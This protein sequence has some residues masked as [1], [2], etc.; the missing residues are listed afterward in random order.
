MHRHASVLLTLFILH[1]CAQQPKQNLLPAT[2]P[3]VVVSPVV[4]KKAEPPA[5][6]V[7]FVSENI[8]AYAEVAK[9]LAK[10]LGKKA[11]IHYLTDSAFDNLRTVSQFKDEP[12]TQFVS[13]GLNAAIASNT[14]SNKQLV[15]CQVYNYQ[16]YA[17]ISSKHKG[18]SMLPSL[19]KTFSIW[20]ALSPTTK[21]IGIITG[22]GFEDVMQAANSAAKK[23]GFTLHF[24]VV[25]TDK[26]YQY[27]YKKM[28]NQVQGYWLLPDNRV[29]SENILRDIMN[30]S[31]RNS[32]QVAVFNDEL[33]KLGGLLSLGSETKDIAQ[34]V[35]ERLEQ[36]QASEQMPGPDIMYP[37]QIKISI[38]TV[39]AKRLNLT[40]PKQYRKYQNA[41]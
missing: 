29:L 24:E 41:P 19:Y 7:I 11:N 33:L 32:K 18:V 36:G 35:L 10:Q 2:M 14:L 27:A 23:Y 12:N 22:P 40:I 31:M 3:E 1:G 17:L 26:E 13:I 37:A 28:S 8:P 4:I 15:F 20:R 16:D 9:A 5:Q 38:N 39:M 30:F 34:Q 21:H 25:K 6:V